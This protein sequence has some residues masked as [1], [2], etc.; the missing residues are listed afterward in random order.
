MTKSHFR[1]LVYAKDKNAPEKLVQ[2]FQEKVILHLACTRL[3]IWDWRWDKNF[4]RSVICAKDV[5][6]LLKLVQ[7]CSVSL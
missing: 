1:S 3:G 2:N 4:S 6:A 7:S 5:N